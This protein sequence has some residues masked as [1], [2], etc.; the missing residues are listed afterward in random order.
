MRFV[1]IVEPDDG[2]TFEM[3]VRNSFNSLLKENKG[4]HI[5][6]LKMFLNSVH[7]DAFTDEKNYVEEAIKTIFKNNYAFIIVIV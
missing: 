1:E 3:K 2:D 5:V 4:K 6:E 7:I